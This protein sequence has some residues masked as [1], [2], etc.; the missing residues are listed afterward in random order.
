MATAPITRA[1]SLVGRAMSSISKFVESTIR[2]HEPPAAGTAASTSSG[3]PAGN[4]SGVIPPY[5]MPVSATAVSIGAK[6]ALR[7]SSWRRT[8][9]L[10]SA[11]VVAST[12][13][14]A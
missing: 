9:P 7:T 6:L 11:R 2:S 14:A 12:R 10:T 1:I 13:Q 3:Q 5:S 4:P 8:T